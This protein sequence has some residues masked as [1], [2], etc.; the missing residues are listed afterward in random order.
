MFA[1]P[2]LSPSAQSQTPHWWYYGCPRGQIPQAPGK[3]PNPGTRG[4][5]RYQSCLQQFLS[6]S[7]QQ[8][9]KIVPILADEGQKVI[10][11]REDNSLSKVQKI[12]AIK[13]LHRQS[14]PQLKALLSSAQYGEAR[15]RPATGHSMGHS[16][17]TR[18]AVTRKLIPVLMPFDP[19]RRAT[20]TEPG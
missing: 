14:D 10:K 8:S 15:S 19:R 13:A 1:L 7:P 5:V 4:W 6:V 2:A 17:K 12:Q 16:G 9:A 20:T 18:L 11:I 3:I